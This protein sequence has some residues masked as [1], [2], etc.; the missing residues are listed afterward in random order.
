MLHC[1]HK[2]VYV[3]INNRPNLKK[4]AQCLFKEVKSNQK[5]AQIHSLKDHNPERCRIR[6]PHDL[7]RSF[8]ALPAVTI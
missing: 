2:V 1:C 6:I 7:L 3:I 5:K 8:P 4:F